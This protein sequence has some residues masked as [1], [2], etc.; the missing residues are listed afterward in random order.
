[1]KTHVAAVHE[2]NKLFRCKICD[3]RF[4]IKGN[5][6]QHVASVHKENKPFKF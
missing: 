1:M 2:E 5:M 3:Y 6:N 4:S